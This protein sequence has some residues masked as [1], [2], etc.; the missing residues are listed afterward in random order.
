LAILTHIIS[1]LSTSFRNPFMTTPAESKFATGE[2]WKI[3]Y[4]VQGSGPALI[5]LHGGGPG[6]TGASNF[7]RNTEALA[8][9]FTVYVIDFPGWGQS[10]KNL[11][12]F[13]SPSPF[14]NGARALNAFMD[15]LGIAKAHVLGNSFGGSAAY[16]LAMEFPDRVDRIVTM[17]PGGA[18]L[19]GQGPT[20]GILQ[21]LSY[22]LGGQPTREKLKAFLGNLVHDASTITDEFIEKRFLASN[23]P[24]IIANPPLI[25]R[26]GN[27][28]PPKEWYLT[29]DPRLAKI[30]HRSLLVWGKQDVVN[31]PEGVKDFSVVP[32][33]EVVLFD[34]CGHWAQ[35]EH[36]DKFN[37]LVIQFLQSS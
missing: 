27:P 3:H 26:P 20:P 31:L 14:V 19:G 29:N 2:G 6:A 30:P 7:S 33:Q 10:S 32:N 22:Y 9:H 28:P 5:L 11:D 37:T 36:A 25:L 35:W 12:S 24:E 4:T 1:R 15:S 13:G 18:W 34:Q 23:D 17:G 21:L 8:K 16:Y